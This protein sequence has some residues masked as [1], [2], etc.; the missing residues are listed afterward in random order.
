MSR[1]RSAGSS[2]AWSTGHFSVRYW[3]GGRRA[4]S[5]PASMTFR[6]ALPR[7]TAATLVS[8]GCHG[9]QSRSS[10]PRLRGCPRSRRGAYL[11][12]MVSNDVEALGVGDCVRGAPA[13]A[14]GA[15]HRSAC[16]SAA[17]RRRLP[18]PHGARP[19]GAR[20]R[21]ARTVALRREVR[22]RARGARIGRSSFGR[23]EGIPTAD[24][25]VPAVEVLDDGARADDRRRRARAA[26]DPRGHS[27]LRPRDRRSRPSCRSGA[28][29]ARDRL[30]E[31][32][33][34]GA[35]ADRAPALPGAREP[36]ASRPRDRAA[37]SCPSTT[38]S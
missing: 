20:S 17:G 8:D 36:H 3:P 6:S 13:D 23:S 31:G 1:G 5:Y 7:N 11:Q 14:E 15:C 34:P 37:P 16:R 28:R 12:A 21:D 9:A 27:A 30:R 26:A 38:P 10:P 33:L 18:A 19:R 29:G 22:D 35:G 4:G 32:L 25:G 24:F 2:P